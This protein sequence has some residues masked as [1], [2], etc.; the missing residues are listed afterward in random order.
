M[1]A[2]SST[3]EVGGQSYT[4]MAVGDRDLEE[5]GAHC[6]AEFCGQLDFLPFKCL[7]CKKTY[8]LDHRTETAHKCP[9]AGEWAAARRKANASSSMTSIPSQKPTLATAKQCSHPKCKTYIN[10]LQNPSVHCTTCNREYCLKHRM[11]E[12]HNCKNL[13]PLG[14]RPFNARLN[15]QAQTEKAKQMF[16][17]L[18]A[19]GK[20]KQAALPK[21]KPKVNSPAARAAAVVQLKKTAKGDNSIPVDKRIYLFVEAEAATTSSKFPKG[22]CF[23]NKQWSIGRVLDAAAKQLQVQNVNN[24]GGGEEERLRVFH[25]EAGRLLEFSEKSGE[26][27]V[28]GNTIVLLRGIGPAVP[29]LIEA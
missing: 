28:N 8:C 11:L 22:E 26:I 24:R 18:R 5:L 9:H 23:F 1:E 16:G 15:A 27:L 13:I 14:A 7:S 25:V 19:W 2:S 29:D 17:K 3:I 4:A 20:E 10:T 21:P 6:Q 12:D